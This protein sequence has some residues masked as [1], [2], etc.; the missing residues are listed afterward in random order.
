MAFNLLLAAALVAA[1]STEWGQFHGNARR[2]G[3]T[4]VSGPTTSAVAS[5]VKL[6]SK[7]SNVSY[8]AVS[9]VIVGPEGVML[10][11]KGWSYPNASGAL[12]C[13]A[14]STTMGRSPPVP[15]GSV[16]VTSV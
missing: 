9:S 6:D 15:A 8:G 12:D 3:Y 16:H 2:T 7:V 13:P 14:T 10:S 5:V 11:R 1:P 4:N